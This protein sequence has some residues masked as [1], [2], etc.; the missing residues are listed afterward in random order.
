MMIESMKVILMT[1]NGTEGEQMKA[2]LLRLLNEISDRQN[3]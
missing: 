1:T 2:Q 3:V